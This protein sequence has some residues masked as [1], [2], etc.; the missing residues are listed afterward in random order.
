M[1]KK[2]EAFCLLVIF[3]HLVDF[4][5]SIRAK[6]KM[7]SLE[8]FEYNDEENT[9]K[10]IGC[11]EHSEAEMKRFY[12]KSIRLSMEKILDAIEFYPPVQEKYARNIMNAS[13]INT[14]INY[15]IHGNT[16]CSINKQTPWQENQISICPHHF[17][18]LRRQDR[19][20][21]VIKH[22]KCNCKSCLDVKSDFLKCLPNYIVKP[23]LIRHMCLSNGYY[24]WKRAFEYVPVSCS[25][26]HLMHV[27]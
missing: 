7:A 18:E 11:K 14:K 27:D 25:C 13:E 24:G 20:P 4:A 5:S 23:V 19:Y 9:V 12:E 1:K 3:I 15:L 10:L 21:F 26:K 17:V 16:N 22:A 2:I 6:R 8:E